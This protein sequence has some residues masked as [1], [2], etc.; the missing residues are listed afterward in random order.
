MLGLLLQVVGRQMA[1]VLVAS[2]NNACRWLSV[3]MH[4]TA[5]PGLKERTGVFLIIAAVAVRQAV[6]TDRVIN[7]RFDKGSMLRRK[8][9]EGAINGY[10]L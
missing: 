6:V 7:A 3:I 2:V 4:E 9:A 8:P 10:R 5:D 1:A